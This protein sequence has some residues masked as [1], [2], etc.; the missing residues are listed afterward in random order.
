MILIL[1]VT[2]S[3]KGRVAFELARAL[4]GE[5]V[6]VDSMKVY[7][8]MDIGT[9]KPPAEARR[10][11]PYHLID[12]VEPSESFSVGLY[13]EKALPA[14]EEIRRRG[15]TVIAV[16]GTALYIKALLY[17]LFE[18]PGSDERIRA[19]L[20]SRAEAEGL[21]RLHG[22]LARVDPE[23]AERINPNDARRIIRALEVHR[24]TGRP[25]SSFQR[26]FEVERPL[27]DWMLIGLR[28]ERALESRRINARVR[29]MVEAGLV[30]EVESLLAEAEPL[31]KQAR[32]AI[33]Y[34]EIIEHLEGRMDRETAV[35]RVK[36]NTRR[37]AKGQRTWF[38]TFR[39]VHW[40]DIEPDEPDK[41]V[42]DRAQKLVLESGGPNPT[43]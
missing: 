32:S 5:I 19:E 30:G 39:G 28:R 21:A 8:R 42:L 23:A 15:R 31:S 7:R 10:G 17:G 22:E 37:L 12:V 16:G 11:V 3:G 41:N 40:I 26:Q 18:G 33:G 34:A 4:D 20:H 24:L 2:A 6:S 14:I 13:L 36:I 35:E 43:G 9:A 38:K 1:G 25:I 27:H 29:K